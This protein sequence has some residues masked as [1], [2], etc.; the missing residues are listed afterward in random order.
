MLPSLFS[1]F[2]DYRCN[3]A[4]AHCSVGSNPRTVMPMPRSL[5]LKW[6]YR[7]PS[8]PRDRCVTGLAITD[9]DLLCRDPPSRG[10]TGGNDLIGD[11]GAV[12]KEKGDVSLFARKEVYA[13]APDAAGAARNDHHCI[14]KC[15]GAEHRHPSA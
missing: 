15:G 4:C 8:D 10:A 6:Y 14:R 9:V 5:L 7:D 3:F 12:A 2:L 11:L 1:V 13:C